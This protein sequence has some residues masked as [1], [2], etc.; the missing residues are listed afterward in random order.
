MAREN[1][2]F[3]THQSAGVLNKNAI[4]NYIKNNA[5]VSRTDIWQKMNL[6]RASVTQIIKQLMEQGF[7]FET[8][9]GQSRGGRKPC[10][11]G[12]NE[13][14]SNILVFNWHLKTLYLTDLNSNIIDSSVL[15]MPANI[16]P[17]D[18]A[19]K[20]DNSVKD[21]MKCHKLNTQKIMGIGLIMPGI[22]D[23]EKGIV[24]YSV[25]HNWRN[26]SLREMVEKSTGMKTIVETD[27]NMN[28][29][30]ECICG[31]GRNIKDFVLFEIEEEGLGIGLIL[32][33]E[34]LRGSNNMIGEIGHIKVSEF[35]LTCRCG[36]EGCLESKIKELLSR[37][38]GNWMCEVANYIGTAASIIINML[39][40]KLIVFSGAVVDKLGD[41]F[42]NEVRN[43]AF[44][45]V[46]NRKHREVEIKRSLLGEKASLK[47][48]CKRIYDINF[49]EIGIS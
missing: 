37:K 2:K 45:S 46:L 22:I 16:K 30:G 10:F 3:L 35:G 21:I 34:L 26:V 1:T 42:I 4:L 48:M 12:F 33:G 14:A 20:L 11:L 15:A 32:N 6:S 36:N 13:N 5:P 25:E 9:V 43:V 49:S 38:E 23:V 8:G 47:G 24:L 44:E 41:C 17:E 18:Y 19:V 39:D 27:G 29:L 40:P 7:V 31:D 28:V